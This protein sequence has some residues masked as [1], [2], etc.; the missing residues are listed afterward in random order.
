[1]EVHLIVEGEEK[2]E[3]GIENKKQEDIDENLLEG[4]Q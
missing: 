1:M 3:K 4:F 2:K